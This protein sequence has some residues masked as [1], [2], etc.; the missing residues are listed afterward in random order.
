MGCIDEN[1][2]ELDENRLKLDEN[3]LE[4]GAFNTAYPAAEFVED[5][6]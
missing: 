3:R 6:G 4:L 2:L 1:R 5:E